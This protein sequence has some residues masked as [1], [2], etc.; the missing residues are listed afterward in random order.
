MQPFHQHQIRHR[1]GLV[2]LPFLILKDDLGRGDLHLCNL[3]VLYHR[4]ERVVIRLC[5][6]RML[7]IGHHE[8]VEDNHDRHHE[9]HVCDQLFPWLLYFIH[10]AVST[11]FQ[12]YLHK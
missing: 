11:P 8:D 2:N 12:S 5:D 4:D 3:V 1:R 9:Q 6:L 7:Q 10:I